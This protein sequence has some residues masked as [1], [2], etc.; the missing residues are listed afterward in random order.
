M[1]LTTQPEFETE[2]ETA[3]MEKTAE[4]EVTEAKSAGAV[5]QIS[6]AVGAVKPRFQPAFGDIKDAFD[7][8]VVAALNMATPRIK[9]EQGGC[10]VENKNLGS[11]IRVQVQSWN[12]R[13]LVSPNVDLSKDPEAKDFLRTSYDN[14]TI[15]GSDLTINQYLQEL[16]DN[17]YEDP[18]VS[19]YADIWVLVTWT[20]KDGD[21]K[22]EEQTMYILQASQTSMGAW[23]AFC[24][25]EGLKASKG[26]GKP[27]DE[28]E[29]TAEPRAKG[30]LKY[31]NFSFAAA[32]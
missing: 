12:N 22:P 15:H 30:N 1:G 21:I 5:A 14:E 18:K 13:W 28:V 11:K 8:D 7:T 20:E 24:T 25:T 19:P 4:P 26:I 6:G 29:I 32:R 9:A 3:T 10:Y 27:F 17:G 23:V 2:A 31:T 16:R